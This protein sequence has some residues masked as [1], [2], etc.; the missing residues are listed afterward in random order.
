[1]L[2][3]H[4]RA[5]CAPHTAAVTE[6]TWPP[7]PHRGVRLLTKLGDSALQRLDCKRV[8]SIFGRCLAARATCTVQPERCK[9][10]HPPRGPMH[11][12][13]D[14]QEPTPFS[15]QTPETVN[16]QTGKTPT[17]LPE[18]ISRIGRNSNATAI[19]DFSPLYSHDF[20]LVRKRTYTR[21][22]HSCHATGTAVRR[23][24]HHNAAKYNLKLYL[25]HIC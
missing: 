25:G 22:T 3:C 17:Y 11:P 16:R 20:G 5:S 18:E 8:K 2:P 12:G 9:S 14:C 10:T 7:S 15:H 6:R 13:N 24:T 23:K 21:P 19:N 4:V 1:M